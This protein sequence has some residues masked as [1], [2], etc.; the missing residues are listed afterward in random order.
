MTAPPAPPAST[1]PAAPPDATPAAT[2]VIFRTDPAGGPPLLCMVERSPKMAFAPGAAV[3]PGGRVDPDDYDLAQQ[4]APG[5][6]RDE[7]AARIAAIRETL[8]ET[9]LAIGINKAAGNMAAINR[10]AKAGAKAGDAVAGGAVEKRGA[11]PSAAE[12]D[13]A[14]SALNGGALFSTLLADFGWSLDLA[15]FVPWS[16]W[17]P[18]GALETRVFDARFYIADAGDADLE[19]A[20][21]LTENMSLF[22]ASAQTVLDRADAGAVTIIFP[23]RRNLERLALFADFAA[24]RDHADAVPVRTVLTFVEERADGRYICL[25]GGHGYPVLEEPM[26]SARRG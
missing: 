7:A 15:S 6:D 8:E 9:G 21:D 22:W 24:A 20:A 26:N 16:R 1:V 4:L 18:P 23:T 12:T 10:D 19:G 11:C 13:K 25:P 2:L 3:F 14:R 5:M 17:R